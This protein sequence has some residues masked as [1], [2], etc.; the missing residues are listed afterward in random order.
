[1]D[2]SI[3]LYANNE[4]IMLFHLTITPLNGIRRVYF[5]ISRKIDGLTLR[6][7]P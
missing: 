5:T 3:H 7:K 4:D 1:M 2:C 6:I